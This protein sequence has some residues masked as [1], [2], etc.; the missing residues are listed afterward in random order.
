MLTPAFHRPRRARTSATTP[1]QHVA[2]AFAIALTTALSLSLSLVTVNAR[3]GSPS[4]WNAPVD[5][6]VA[7]H[8]GVTV[9]FQPSGSANIAFLAG[10][11]PRPTATQVVHS[12]S[13]GTYGTPSTL[14]ALPRN[15]YAQAIGFD[16][17]GETIADYVQSWSVRGTTNVHSN[18]YLRIAGAN[19]AFG[20]PVN[21]HTAP[22]RPTSALSV[23]PSGAAVTSISSHGGG[24]WNAMLSLRKPGQAFSRPVMLPGSTQIDDGPPAVAID[25]QG[26]FVVAWQVKAGLRA[27]T[28][29]V[30]SGLGASVLL[31]AAAPAALHMTTVPELQYLPR[32]AITNGRAVV[33]WRADSYKMAI[34][35]TWSCWAAVAEPG[36]PF[37]RPAQLSQACG[38]N[39]GF[40][41]SSP[42]VAVT[43]DSSALALVADNPTA[44]AASRDISPNATD[45][46][47]FAAPA[48]QAFATTPQILAKG[49]DFAQVSVAAGQHGE[50][51]ATFIDA[52][53]KVSAQGSLF[54]AYSS[55]G[56]QF[57]KAGSLWGTG[58]APTPAV[59]PNGQAVVAWTQGLN[60]DVMVAVHSPAVVASSPTPG[61]PAAPL[62]A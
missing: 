17:A 7:T 20:A 26:N 41:P 9:A 39:G 40:G 25:A 22:G 6:H 31:A 50:A 23:A 8:F 30:N 19:G 44:P 53:K 10:D 61:S 47:A 33:G 57:S 49:T 35:E 5:L 3:A 14:L 29:N 37:G 1:L 62:S 42:A 45:V 34:D 4:G 58:F 12:G 48:G 16:A 18:V 32:V 59:S 28:G 38:G 24:T 36:K 54:V 2:I 46:Q 55:A 51:V 27:A 21:L 56:G 60:G 13:D 15:A 52:G 11:P 43:S